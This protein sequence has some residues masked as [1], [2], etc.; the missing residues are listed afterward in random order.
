[1]HI[2]SNVRNFFYIITKTSLQAHQSVFSTKKI[3][4]I[5]HF[6]FTRYESFFFLKKKTGTVLGDASG[7]VPAFQAALD[8]LNRVKEV[9][10]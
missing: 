4:V 3:N 9:C 5:I 2:Q 10:I 8:D 7:G 6:V 1:M